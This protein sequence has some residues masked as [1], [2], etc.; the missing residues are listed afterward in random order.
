MNW[1]I[2]ALKMRLILVV[3]HAVKRIGCLCYFM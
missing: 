3:V 1:F 2:D